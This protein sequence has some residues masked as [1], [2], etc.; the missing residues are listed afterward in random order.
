MSTPCQLQ[1][2]DL[3][4]IAYEPALEVQRTVQR[5]VIDQRGSENAQLFHLLVLEHDPP[6]ITISKRQ[7]VQQHL[8]ATEQQLDDAGVTVTNTDRGGDITYHGPGQL[9]GYSICDLNALSLRLHGYMRF[10]ES[11]I[12]D[13]LSQFDLNA[14]RDDCSTGV[15]V[16][17]SKICAMGV[18]VSRW[19]S[20]HG[21]A[22]NV[23]PNLS[24]FDLIVPCGLAGRTVTSMSQ[25]L[26]DNCPSM[27]EVKSVVGKTFESAIERQA[28]V[29]PAPRQ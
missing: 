25:L 23:A 4:K 29:Q 27:D 20:M 8:L 28:Q 18:R 26:G 3:G 9:V 10:L 13:V 16:G 19:V 7:G 6:V 5:S 17:D 24:H 11:C 15:W 14:Q 22:I 2:Q 21:F 12:I 1:I